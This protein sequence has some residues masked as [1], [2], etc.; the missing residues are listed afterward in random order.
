MHE[1]TGVLLRPVATAPKLERVHAQAVAIARPGNFLPGADRHGVPEQTAEPSHVEPNSF[2]T[3][4]PG[5]PGRS[6]AFRQRRHCGERADRR[7]G[8][9]SRK[10]DQ[11]G[12]FIG[13]EGIGLIVPIE[14]MRI[15]PNGAIAVLSG[16]E[17][18]VEMLGFF[19]DAGTFEVGKWAGEKARHSAICSNLRN[20]RRS[21]SKTKGASR[22]LAPTRSRC[23]VDGAT[24]LP[25]W[26]S[27]KWH[28]SWGRGSAACCEKRSITTSFDPE[29]ETRAAGE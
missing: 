27:W 23:V 24:S 14:K 20:L 19:V 18:G 17:E 9:F 15:R 5:S 11:R 13:A 16:M 26:R 10:R 12:T 4:R 21:D 6:H 7:E 8:G 1:G 29:V 28:G 3:F 25:P 22:E 2:D